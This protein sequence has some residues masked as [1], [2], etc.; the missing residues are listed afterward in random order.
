M[1]EPSENCDLRVTYFSL[2]KKKKTVFSP[3]KRRVGAFT[4]TMGR[5]LRDVLSI[6]RDLLKYGCVGR[7]ED[8]S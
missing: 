2:K 3:Q 4:S 7:L 8:Q 5:R 1:S 6:A